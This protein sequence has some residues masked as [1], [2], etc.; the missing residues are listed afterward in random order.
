MFEILK[1]KIIAYVF[2]VTAKRDI[3]G[4]KGIA[5]GLTVQVVE[6]RSSKPSVN[7]ILEAYKN[8]L[9]IELPKSLGVSDGCFTWERI[10]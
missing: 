4:S 1:L 7:H 8:Q 3:G 9:G 5:K 10:K 2:K 6:P